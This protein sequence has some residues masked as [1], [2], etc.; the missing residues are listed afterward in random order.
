[1][2]RWM[3]QSRQRARNLRHSRQVGR[4]T[5]R[6]CRALPTP[7]GSSGGLMATRCPV[8]WVPSS[9]KAKSLPMQR[10]PPNEAAAFQICESA[11]GHTRAHQGTPRAHQQEQALRGHSRSLL[12]PFF[13]T[14][15]G[16]IVQQAQEPRR[17]RQRPLSVPAA[18]PASSLLPSPSA[19]GALGPGH[20]RS[21]RA[22][23]FTKEASGWSPPDIR[24]PR[25]S[26]PKHGPLV[27]VS[28]AKRRIPRSS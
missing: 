1:M 2:H 22:P 27:V 13:E 16:H 28:L 17:W 5:C 15:D 23:V 6:G 11:G 8:Q 9:L 25:R 3:S 24:K 7:E 26:G 12:P 18:G 19:W 14:T 4:G 10:L 21:L 20:S